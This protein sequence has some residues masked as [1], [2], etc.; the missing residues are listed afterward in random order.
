MSSARIGVRGALLC[1]AVVLAG[2]GQWALAQSAGIQ[3]SGGASPFDTLRFR[4]IGPATMAGRIDDFAVL[5]SDPAT[6]YVAA[7]T[8]GLWKTTN[9]GTTFETVFDDESTSSIGDVAIAPTDANLV[10]V[11]TG[12]N[13]NRQS[14]SWGEGVFKSTDGG[15]SWANM[16]LKDS[17]HI[18]RVV[19]DPVDHDVV[20]AAVLGSLWAAAASGASTGRRTAATPGISCWRWTRT[21]VPPTSSWTRRTTRSCTRRPTSGGARRGASTAAGR[22]ARSTSRPTPGESWTELTAGLPEGPKGRI[23]LDIYRKNPN[24]LYAQIEHP[25]DGGVYRTDDGGAT[26]EQMSDTNPRP[27]YFSQIR[28]GPAGRSPD[29]RAGHA[30]VRL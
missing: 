15:K 5:E 23:G 4:P 24:V 11:G 26:W 13:N 21:P 22:A 29:L 10:W 18:A 9:N 2:T 17:H 3:S 16:G 20:Y 1:A 8:G 27:M 28:I 14:S 12:E 6:F 7:A 19:I 25:D 30:V